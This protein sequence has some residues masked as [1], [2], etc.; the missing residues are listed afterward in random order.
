MSQTDENIQSTSKED[1]RLWKKFKNIWK[2][3]YSKLIDDREDQNEKVVRIAVIGKTGVGKGSFIN[4]I[5]G[6]GSNTIGSATV[7][8][9]NAN[10]THGV[11]PGPTSIEKYG[12]PNNENPIIYFYDTGGF[13]DAIN[14]TYNLEEKLTK[15]QE[16]NKIKFDAI[17][18]IFDS[19][20]FIEEEIQPLKD[21]ENKVCL[22]L[23]IANQIDVLKCKIDNEGEFQE[24]KGKLKGNYLEVLKIN[25]VNK[26]DICENSIYLISSKA[27]KFENEDVSPDGK[28]IKA[29]LTELLLKIKIGEP[30]DLFNQFTRQLISYKA[31]FIQNKVSKK[32]FVSAVKTSPIAIIP[33]AD[34]FVQD[35]IISD[36]KD[37]FL[38]QFGI[39]SVMDL[40]TNNGDIENSEHHVIIS[41]DTEKWKRI[42]MLVDEIKE[43]KLLEAI[44]FI[45]KNDLSELT[46]AKME[47]LLNQ[48]IGLLGGFV[49]NLSDEIALSLSRVAGVALKS[50]AAVIAAVTFPI[51]IGHYI[52]FC[53]FAIMKVIVELTNYAIKIHDVLHE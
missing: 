41:K 36:Y 42:K 14:K 24:E 45:F 2:N 19:T 44:N 9:P 32:A 40:I 37:V 38:N 30:L 11:L 7:N 1:H 10:V 53:H 33:F 21:Q 8:D 15:Y 52:K 22:I 29:E 26:H 16:E 13:G 6:I 4:T 43:N 18:F 25:K 31:K 39:K 34:I 12:Y 49:A 35:K 17:A 51:A 27:S 5:R 23:Y 46:I 28:R 50:Y 48:V 3:D 47:S 20:R